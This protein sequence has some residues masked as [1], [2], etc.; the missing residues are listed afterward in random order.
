[1]QHEINVEKRL[2]NSNGL[3]NEP[4]YAKKLLLEYERNDI[5]ANK[6]RIK[7][8]DY[9]LIN[10]DDFALALTISDN[11]YMGLDSVSFMD[12]RTKW[13]HT[14]T[15]MSF[16]TKG[17]KAL[18]S[19]SKYGDT[20][21]YGKGYKISFMNDGNKRTLSVHL[22]SF[23]KNIKLDALIELTDEPL[24]STV[25]STPFKRDKR[26]FYYN[27]KINCIKAQGY[28]DFNNTRYEFRKEDSCA[29][30]DWGRGVWTYKNTW[31]WGSA[32]GYVDKVPFGFN[33]GYGFGDT[34]AASENMIIYDNKAHKLENVKFVIS[35][36][37]G[38]E[39]YLSPWRFISS[40]NRFTMDFVPIIDRSAYTSLGIIKSDQ[41][42]VFGRFSGQAIL[43]NKKMII[44]KDLL[45]FAEK[46]FNKW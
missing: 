8:W 29:V 5:S 22:D 23:L 26:A 21:S 4:G 40:D 18:P 28:V 15:F 46:V 31:Y 39:D 3:L 45:G 38:K 27:Q 41:H 1:M 14:K 10:N 9:Y 11:S 35:M 36:K 30:L 16:M 13:H 34:S 19:S 17:K 43:D 24:E 2:L 44:V 32:S 20:K 37:D 33:I 7:E 12:F 25:M 42:Q 6:L